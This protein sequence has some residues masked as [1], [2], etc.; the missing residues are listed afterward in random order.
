MIDGYARNEG[1]TWGVMREACGLI[2][3]VQQP[4]F[5]GGLFEERVGYAREYADCQEVIRFVICLM[6]ICDI[7]YV[8][9]INVQ[10]SK[11]PVLTDLL[12]VLIYSHTFAEDDIYMEINTW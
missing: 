1:N 3:V 2:D 6:C 10:R 12:Y 7:E 11:S 5:E 8:A 4:K 9:D